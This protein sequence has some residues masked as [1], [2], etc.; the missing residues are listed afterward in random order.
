MSEL[1]ETITSIVLACLLFFL[2]GMPIILIIVENVKKKKEFEALPDD[3]DEKIPDEV[4]EEKIG[5]R[6]IYLSAHEQAAYKSLS[7]KQKR[8]LL[9]RQ[10]AMINQGKLFVVDHH[11]NGGKAL[12]TRLEALRTGVITA[13]S[14]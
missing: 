10:T 2:I 9:H 6:S 11:K 4:F 14:E 8:S 13:K 5:N 12:I 1:T 3:P 7:F